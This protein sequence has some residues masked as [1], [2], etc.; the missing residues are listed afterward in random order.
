M[1]RG[2]KRRQV[3]SL[4][5]L[6]FQSGLM[7]ES[8]ASTWKTP[9]IFLSWEQKEKPPTE[10]GTAC[11][12]RKRK[13]IIT[14]VYV[15]ELTVPSPKNAAQQDAVSYQH[16]YIF[17]PPVLLLNT[18]AYWG[19]LPPSPPPLRQ[20]QQYMQ[21]P[22]HADSF[23]VLLCQIFPA[24]SKENSCMTDMCGLMDSELRF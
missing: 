2:S 7:G 5:P 17:P 4:Q 16:S 3:K 18:E 15:N 11:E 12:L 19:L 6:L 21:S 24:S 22:S 20:S 13:V 10:V 1:M 23:K 9:K 14:S 8:S